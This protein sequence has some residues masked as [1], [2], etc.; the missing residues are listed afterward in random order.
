MHSTTFVLNGIY[1]GV[2]KDN[3]DPQNLRRLKLQVS[4]TGAE[5]TDWVWPLELYSLN[6]ELPKIGQG[7][8]VGYIGG[9]PEYP[10]WLGVFAKQ[11][12]NSKKVYVKG[13]PNSVNLT[14][15]GLTP[16]VKLISQPDNTKELDLVDTLLAMARTLKDH[17]QR[18]TALEA[19][20]SA[21]HSTLATRSSANHTH[22]SAG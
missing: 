2:V 17:E 7:V 11:S 22:T 16:Y 8:W 9:N 13:L 10:V 19:N 5:T 18:I 14:S 21:L 1:R 3:K 15:E 20:L 4:T 12:E 6:Y